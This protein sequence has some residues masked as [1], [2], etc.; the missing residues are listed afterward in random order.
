M[1]DALLIN[2]WRETAERS[3]NHGDVGETEWGNV[4]IGVQALNNAWVAQNISGQ[5]IFLGHFYY[6]ALSNPLFLVWNTVVTCTVDCNNQQNT[7]MYQYPITCIFSVAARDV[8]WCTSLAHT[9]RIASS[10]VRE[11]TMYIASA[12]N[13]NHSEMCSNCTTS[14]KEQCPEGLSKVC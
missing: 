9:Q 8:K 14:C 1:L 6:L 7:G 2:C 10:A 3:T 4:V 11:D 13:S 5:Y 12:N